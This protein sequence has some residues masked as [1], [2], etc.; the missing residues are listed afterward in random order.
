[1]AL[2]HAIGNERT[3]SMQQSFVI[4]KNSVTRA[5][6]AGEAEA[7]FDDLPFQKL[8]ELP[9]QVDDFRRSL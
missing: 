5:Q 4:K 1:M 7:S 8:V 6:L 2:A 9:P 3:P